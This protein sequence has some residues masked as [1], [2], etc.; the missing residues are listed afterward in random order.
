MTSFL[1]QQARWEANTVVSCLECLV[2]AKPAIEE[3]ATTVFLFFLYFYNV[4][5]WMSHIWVF[6]FSTSME[7]LFGE[8]F[9]IYIQGVGAG[10]GGFT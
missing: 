5:C 8:S 6:P 10:N 9:T 4:L 1:M 2:Y 7:R 3:Q